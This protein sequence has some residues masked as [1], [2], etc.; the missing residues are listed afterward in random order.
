[1]ATATASPPS[2]SRL[3]SRRP[4]RSERRRELRSAALAVLGLLVVLVGVP[5]ALVLGVGNPLP[6]S[7]PD[8][9]W[10]TA[11]I[12]A[13][14]VLQVLAG[15]LWLV[16]AHF[17]VCVLTE[18]RAAR[19][20]R[21]VA[22][23]VPLGG[24]SQLLARRLVAAALLLAGAATLVP[25]GTGAPVAAPAAISTSVAQQAGPG[26]SQQAP[27]ADPAAAPEQLPVTTPAAGPAKT[28]VVQPPAGRRYDS[29]WDIAERTLGDPFRYREI[30]ELNR[31]KVQDDGRK[32][33]DANLIHPGWVLTMPADAR[34]PGVGTPVLAPPQRPAPQAPVEAAA[35]TAQAPSVAAQA[36]EAPAGAQAVEATAGP[37]TERVLLG[38][39]LLAA[40][41]L[42][43][44]SA[45]RG[46]YGRPPVAGPEEQ[47]RLAATPQRAG[48]LDRA[49]RGLADSCATAARPL[50]E[51]AVAYCDE[52][53]VTL[54]LVGP[55][56][57]PPAP[58]TPVS[59]GR[60]WTVR[61]QDV[62][63]PAPD[64]A[65]PYPA[66]AGIALSGHTDVLVDLEAAPGLVSLEGDPVV[67]REIAASLLVELAT[68][69]WS[70]GVRVT[71][72]GFGDD[73]TAVDPD[74]LTVADTLSDV[75]AGLEAESRAARGWLQSLGEGD[76]LAGRAVRGADRRPPRVVV[77]SGPPTG[78]EAE[79]LHALVAGGRTPLA[80]VCVGSSAAARWRFTVDASG[81][82]D[83]GVLGLR[84]AARR[85]SREAYLPLLQALRNA[86]L[87]RSAGS[88]AIGALSPR[89]ALQEVTGAGAGAAVAAAPADRPVPAVLPQGPA[90][91]E[92][93]LLGPV[94]VLAP[95]PVDP[96]ARGLLTELVV[97]AALH[98]GGL[99]EAVLRAE[100]WP[101]GVGDDVLTAAVAQAQAWLG[102]AADGLPRLR[103]DGHG[104]YVLSSEV[105]T[106]W[107]LLQAGAAADGPG[108]YAALE[109][110][111]GAV[112]GEA[113]TAAGPGFGS[114]SFHRSARDARV[115]GTAVAR[116]AASLAGA[117][118]DRP[119]AVRLLRAGLTLVPAAEPLWRDLLRLT[120][121]GE[122]AAQVVRE[123]YTALAAHGLRAE[124][125]TDALVQQVAPGAARG[126]A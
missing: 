65:A 95:G 113:F 54:S 46:P 14:T 76:V 16:W 1:M 124:P 93:R 29:L 53:H 57:E 12:T 37:A 84:G 32:L 116:R 25:S 115:V 15:A 110:A 47:L 39:G 41:V 108:E 82:L 17:A 75:L 120:A 55:A 74:D 66:L 73:F 100:V 21:G 11:Q 44:L 102:T 64:V 86:D 23:Q 83:L 91:V 72:V 96:A 13:G 119:A 62:P 94:E 63:E 88:S 71:A 38:G 24:G 70:D 50:P 26:V 6:T 123:L 45:R 52:E 103:R 20:D 85:L 30:F 101:R 118:G 19:R 90:A 114:L 99:H 42:V 36:V 89:A 56:A 122:P 98:R 3:P 92:V 58:W 35:D 59:D 117:R 79:R 109:S 87:E 34:G 5:A 107:D 40:G 112:R 61:A 9:G 78:E 7:L 31:A 81:S 68:N 105:H 2:V 67:A 28:Y 126:T 111:L 8:R 27:T 69:L 106:D 10:L 33:V 97:A 60:G 121:P 49:L 104:R 43:A 22:S 48:L 80:V 77:L 18:W 51:I 125:E 4:S